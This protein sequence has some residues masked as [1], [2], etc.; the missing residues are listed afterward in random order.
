MNR[1]RFLW[2]TEFDYDLLLKF[3]ILSFQM[4]KHRTIY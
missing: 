2:D 3:I 1:N 4:T